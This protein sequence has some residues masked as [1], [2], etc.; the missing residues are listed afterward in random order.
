MGNNIINRVRNALDS[1]QPEIQSISAIV[2]MNYGGGDGCRNP[3]DLYMNKL[4]N[5]KMAGSVADDGVK[6]NQSFLVS[7]KL[8]IH[9]VARVF[10]N[11]GAVV[12]ILAR[13]FHPHSQHW[14]G[15]S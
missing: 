4:G 14:S 8:G 7:A 15:E 5:F 1:G 3:C 10:D 11:R 9:P 12:V 13:V 6:R 2:D